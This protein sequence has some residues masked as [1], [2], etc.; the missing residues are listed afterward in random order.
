[1]LIAD[2][3]LG[4]CMG[5]AACTRREIFAS[6]LFTSNPFYAVTSEYHTHTPN[7]AY[8]NEQVLRKNDKTSVH[9]ITQSPAEYAD[10]SSFEAP[11][12]ISLDVSKEPNVQ[13]LLT[14]INCDNA[15]RIS[16]NI[17]NHNSVQSFGN[18]DPSSMQEQFI[19][20]IARNVHCSRM[21]ETIDGYEVLVQ[22]TYG[23]WL[24]Q[25]VTIGCGGTIVF[26]NRFNGAWEFYNRWFNAVDRLERLLLTS[27]DG[28]TTPFVTA[29]QSTI[30]KLRELDQGKSL[31]NFPDF[32]E[33]KEITEDAFKDMK[34]L[35]GKSENDDTSFNE[36]LTHAQ[37]LLQLVS[38]TYVR[39]GYACGWNASN[40][41]NEAPL[42]NTSALV[43]NGSD[44]NLTGGLEEGSNRCPVSSSSIKVSKL[45]FNMDDGQCGAT[46]ASLGPGS[47][48]NTH[49]N[50]VLNINN[51]DVTG[52]CVQ[53]IR[54]RCDDKI[55]GN[56][57]VMP[58]AQAIVN[59]RK[60]PSD[61]KSQSLQKTN[62]NDYTVLAYDEQNEELAYKKENGSG[63]C[64]PCEQLLCI[65]NDY[66]V[67]QGAKECPQCCVNIATVG[68]AEA[69]I[70]KK[71]QGLHE[72]FAKNL[73]EER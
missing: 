12:S 46:G 67:S 43:L 60:H 55:V 7:S 28:V 47:V 49:A 37:F 10:V 73:Q 65:V 1:M 17:V 23:L 14:A 57:I 59:D 18:N 44:G 68:Q 13:K 19:Q 41:L 21:A 61:V 11:R 39:R 71:M 36:I 35:F 6:Q 52:F 69:A 33:I 58:T 31:N 42:K 70:R 16:K 53:P 25:H 50:K 24:Q 29:I 48:N 15:T 40:N 56:R 34:D 5:D 66:Y 8:R 72:N 51:Q 20:N 45:S 54:D 3:S 64:R 27:V 2:E 9:L 22:Y 30:E 62:F 32:D 63:C 38:D 4:A 26:V